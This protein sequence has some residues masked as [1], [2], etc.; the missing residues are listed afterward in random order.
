MLMCSIPPSIHLF[1]L[2]IT[3]TFLSSANAITPHFSVVCFSDFKYH[4]SNFF[5]HHDPSLKLF[6]KGACNFCEFPLRQ[7]QIFVQRYQKERKRLIMSLLRFVLRVSVI[8]LLDPEV[9][10]VLL[11]VRL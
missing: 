1:K 4:I 5:D 9:F 3:L 2:V 10:Q 11:F 7:T 8:H 6:H